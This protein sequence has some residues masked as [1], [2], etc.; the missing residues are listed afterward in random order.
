MTSS[1]LVAVPIFREVYSYHGL[2]G[3]SKVATSV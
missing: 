2:L 3:F 1:E